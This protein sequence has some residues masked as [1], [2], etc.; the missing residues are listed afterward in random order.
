MVIHREYV[1][2]L[3]SEKGGN[4]PRYAESAC[5]HC[6]PSL[7]SQWLDPEMLRAGSALGCHVSIQKKL[8]QLPLSTFA[9]T[10]C[11]TI[12]STCCKCVHLRQKMI[13]A[14]LSL[15]RN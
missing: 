10:Y 3:A 15:G 5:S 7:G 4:L 14:R 8:S 1:H 6:K 12:Q 9:Y 11:S 2:S 13:K